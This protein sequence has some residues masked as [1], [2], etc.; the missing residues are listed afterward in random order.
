MPLL[1][2]RDGVSEGVDGIRRELS[3]WI[4]GILR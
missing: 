4:G 1:D 3:G 2:E